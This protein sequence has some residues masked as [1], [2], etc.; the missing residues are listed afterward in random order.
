MIV[1]ILK[2]W[3]SG[4]GKELVPGDKI[5]ICRETYN[6]LISEG[7][8]EPLKGEKIEKKKEKKKKTKKKEI[9]NGIDIESTNN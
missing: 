3:I 4:Q 8:C 6:S 9:E 5:D 1:T 2:N 7:I